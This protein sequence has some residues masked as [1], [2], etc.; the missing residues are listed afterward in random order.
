MQ[1]ENRRAEI[2]IEPANTGITAFSFNE[3]FLNISYTPS[4]RAEAKAKNIHI[5]FEFQLYKLRCDDF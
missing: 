4:N 1:H 2:K 3:I 5:N